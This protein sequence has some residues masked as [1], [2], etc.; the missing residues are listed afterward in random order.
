MIAEFFVV[1]VDD[2]DERRKT[3]LK[4][5]RLLAVL[6]LPLLLVD[7]F[8][9]ALIVDAAIMAFVWCIAIV[10]HLVAC[11]Y[12]YTLAIAVAIHVLRRGGTWYR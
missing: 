3:L 12:W 11:K 2:F 8:W 9:E 4:E 1:A 10:L 6:A 5:I 7:Q